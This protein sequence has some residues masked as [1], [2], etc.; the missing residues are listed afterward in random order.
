ML[1]L[2]KKTE[3][4]HLGHVT[5]DYS[6]WA[7]YPPLSTLFPEIPGER[8]LNPSIRDLC[9]ARICVFGH[10]LGTRVKYEVYPFVSMTIQE[11]S[12][13]CLPSCLRPGSRECK[14]CDHMSVWCPLNGRTNIPD[15][16]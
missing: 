7:E 16:E 12:V 14:T 5:T 2:Q 9:E 4:F 15:N 11:T 1:L 10:R 8:K 13:T 6:D 3:Q